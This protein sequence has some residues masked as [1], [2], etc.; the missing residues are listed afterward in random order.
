MKFSCSKRDLAQ[1]LSTVGH[2][3]PSRSTLPIL[4]NVLLATDHGR[5]KLTATDLE[6]GINCWVEAEI[7]EEGSVALPAK[8][9]TDFVNSLPQGQV[10][11]V[12]LEES[13]TVNVTGGPSSANIRGM[14]PEEFPRIDS[15][16]EGTP[17]IQI[18][19]ALLK[20]VIGQ[21][22]YAASSD[23]S[24]PVLTAVLLQASEEQITFA[25]A[26]AFRLAV[27]CVP[28]ALTSPPKGQILVPAKTMSDLARILPDEGEVQI[29]ITENRSQVLFHTENIALLSRLIE[30]SYPNYGQIIP[31][32]HT[33]RAV[34]S[35]QE[36]AAAMKSASLFARDDANRTYFTIQGTGEEPESQGSLLIEAHA[37]DVGG[38][39]VS[40]SAQ[41]SGPV[42]EMKIV[43]NAPYITQVLAA[44][45]TPEIALELTK[46]SK[47]GVIRPVGTIDFTYVA[48]PM[49]KQS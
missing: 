1:G 8:L 47:P 30:G 45:D 21:V 44:L 26:D 16:E 2:A 14:D 13:H 29:L 36:F 41:V 43:F 40:I 31:K 28:V 27:R 42:Q 34:L 7:S 32:D 23:I 10:E 12:L 35:T 6:I 9:M 22:A 46:E 33:T 19:A 48:M 38:G 18:G 15:V 4:S 37:E 24:R 3:V 5:L 17:S 11:L 39:K 25:A 20:E 49:S